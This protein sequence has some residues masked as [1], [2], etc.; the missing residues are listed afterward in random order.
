VTAPVPLA[1]HGIPVA[2]DVS[3]FDRTETHHRLVAAGPFLR[4][5]D[6]TGRIEYDDARAALALVTQSAWCD[7]QRIMWQRLVLA[8][9]VPGQPLVRTLPDELLDY[10]ADQARQHADRLD[11]ALAFVAKPRL[12][13]RW[14]TIGW[15]ASPTLA[16]RYHAADVEPGLA[17]VALR[18][19]VKPEAVERVLRDPGHVLTA[20]LRDLGR[21]P[22]KLLE[23]GLRD[24]VLD[25]FRYEPITAPVT[26]AGDGEAVRSL[27][28]TWLRRYLARTLTDDPV[29]R[30]RPGSDPR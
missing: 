27:R 9:H 16:G 5:L 26:R 11:A 12:R 4:C 30:R 21:G 19:R 10:L 2:V 3:A 13:R 6:H 23:L 24:A 20:A 15:R 14:H 17:L 28:P 25:D 7:R 22:I 8:D 1:L 29:V 18:H